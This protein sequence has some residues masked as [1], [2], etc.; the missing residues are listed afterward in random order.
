MNSDERF[1]RQRF[2]RRH[3]MRCGILGVGLCAATAFQNR[4]GG[5]VARAV[6]IQMKDGR[7]IQ[8]AMASISS[9]AADAKP[10]HEKV[11][12]IRVIDDRLRRTYVPRAQIVDAGDEQIVETPEVFELRQR[13]ASSDTGLAFIGTVLKSEPFDQ[14]GRRTITLAGARGPMDVIQAITRIEPK[15]I[16]VQGVNIG[17]DMRLATTNFPTD[18]LL[19]ILLRTIVADNPDHYKRV[20]RFFIQSERYEAAAQVLEKL[21]AVQPNEVAQAKMREELTPIITSVRNLTGDYLYRELEFRQKAGQH[22]LVAAILERFPVDGA[23]GRTLVGVREMLRISRQQQQDIAAISE[24]LAQCLAEIPSER[25]HDVF[26]VICDEIRLELAPEVIDRFAAFR[27][28]G[29]DMSKSAE[30]RMSLAVTGWLAGTENA[31]TRPTLAQSMIRVRDRML[32]YLREENDL[33]RSTLVG[34]WLSEESASVSIVADILSNMKPPLVTELPKPVA[35]GEYHVEV[36]VSTARNSPVLRYRIQ[37]PLEYNPLRRYPTVVA[38]HG[39]A[40]DA[41]MEI[42]WWAGTRRGDDPAMERMGQA[43]RRGFIILA[44]EWATPDQMEYGFSAREHAMVLMS[45]RDAC[46]KVAIDTDRIFL[47]G[48]SMGGDAAWDIGPAHPDLWAGV[49]P[50]TG[51][52]RMYGEHLYINTL[53][54]PMYV[55]CGEKD[56]GRTVT[57]SAR[58]LDKMMLRRLCNV[59]V[60]EFIG[61]GHDDFSDEIHRL[62]DWMDLQKRDFLPTEFDVRMMRPWDNFYWWVELR[63]VPSNLLVEPTEWAVRRSPRPVEIKAKVGAKKDMLYVQSPADE[64]ILWASPELLSIDENVSIRL[65]GREIP[66]R[67]LTPSIEILLEDVRSRSDL[68]H[69]FSIRVSSQYKSPPVSRKTS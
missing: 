2:S 52:T 43:S 12:P 57:D 25:G 51:T 21:I 19:A 28:L 38:L 20:A 42:D 55:V 60:A 32:E 26:A 18:Q 50:I 33:A 8:G 68:K 24:Q 49:I 11:E 65:N 4:L 27:T 1:S 40:S 61:R 37:L 46:R 54:V 44:P 58:V 3:L 5:G 15:W 35:T 64:V 29:K 23:S 62:Y 47:T 67:R 66:I 39:E 17:W 30:E 16:R 13:V 45:L 9:V 7:R 63:G 56:P 41:G 48:H 6:E 34:D 31:T 14:F 69:P 36:P 22:R 59:T 53:Y 10:D